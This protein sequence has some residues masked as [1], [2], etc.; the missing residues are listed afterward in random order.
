[1]LELLRYLFYTP[2][3]L[4]FFSVKQVVC[5]G[6]GAGA[7]IIT[8]FAVSQ[9]FLYRPMTYFIYYKYVWPFSL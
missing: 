4:L 6:E 8:R 3:F 5:I 2:V 9:C 1:M 7:N